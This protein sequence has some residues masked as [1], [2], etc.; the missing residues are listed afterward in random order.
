MIGSIQRKLHAAH[1]KLCASRAFYLSTY[2]TQTQEML[3]DART[4]AFTALGS[5]A[6]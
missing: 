3:Y 4:R 2:P 1:T 6:K 5:I